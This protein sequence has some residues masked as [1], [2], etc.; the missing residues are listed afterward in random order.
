MPIVVVGKNSFLANHIVG[1]ESCR[2][3]LFLTHQEALKSNDWIEKSDLVINFAFAPELMVDD[4]DPMLD[5]DTILAEKIEH[6]K[7]IHYI[8]LS[9]RTVYGHSI[10]ENHILKESQ[11]P[12]PF[13]AYGQS[14]LKIEQSLI[15]ILGNKRLTILRLAN[16]FG[17]EPARHTFFGRALKTLKE[18]K[19]IKTEK[20][21]SVLN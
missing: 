15:D 2:D 20:D 13:T 18:E 12:K 10:Y 1:L 4:Y 11:I 3:W 8:M 7:S 19:K 16:I 21:T 6:K 14:K 5:I 17:Y 9:T